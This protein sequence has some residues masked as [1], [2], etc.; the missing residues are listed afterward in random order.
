MTTDPW[1]LPNPVMRV[2]SERERLA[3]ATTALTNPGLPANERA[4]WETIKIHSEAQIARWEGIIE[5]LRE[6]T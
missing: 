3:E 1:T 4:M 2:A 5:Q 6:Q